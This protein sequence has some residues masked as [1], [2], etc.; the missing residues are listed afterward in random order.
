MARGRKVAL[1]A[2]DTRCGLLQGSSGESSW[3]VSDGAGAPHSTLC[4]P[5]WP[6]T[7]HS[8]IGQHGCWP[9]AAFCEDAGYWQSGCV[10]KNGTGIRKEVAEL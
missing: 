5:M 4:P 2:E 10:P 9:R 1:G 8:C 7:Q 3:P 6:G